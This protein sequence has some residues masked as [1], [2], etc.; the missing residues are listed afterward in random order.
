MKVK[1]FWTKFI[2]LFKG[3]EKNDSVELV[4]KYL[5]KAI[6]ENKSDKIL[7]TKVTLSS[8]INFDDPIFF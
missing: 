7:K 1:T 3:F 2:F 5:N 8:E 6:I 4:K